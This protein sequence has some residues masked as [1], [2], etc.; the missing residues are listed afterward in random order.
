MKKPKKKNQLRPDSVTSDAFHVGIELELLAP[1]TDGEGDH[2]DESCEASYRECIDEGAASVLRNEFGLSRDQASQLEDYFQYD[3]WLDAR[4]EGWYCDDSEC[5]HRSHNGDAKREE[6]E[7][8]L[9]RITGNDS[10]KVVPDTSV[11]TDG[12]STDA[13]VCWNYFAS[14]ET[15]RDNAKILAYLTDEGCTF[16]QSCG[17]HINLNNY[18]ELDVAEIPTEKLDFLFNFVGASRR[19]STFCTRMGVSNSSKYSMIYHQRDRLEFRFFS[20]TL[21][22]VKLNHYVTLAN[23]V[24]R[25]LAGQPAKLPKKAMI[26]FLEKMVKV[27]GVSEEVA[28]DSLKKVNSL[29]SLAV[30]KAIE[31]EREAAANM[32]AVA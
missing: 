15:I 22:P 29:K 24:Y 32:E 26:Y 4:M 5:G 13:E 28:K 31:S 3:A 7:A 2:D 20:P 27:N 8:D 16:N 23:T 30:F 11:K 12:D 19:K 6:M 25:R 9:T 14:K 17:L 1:C 21:D 10:F 18:L